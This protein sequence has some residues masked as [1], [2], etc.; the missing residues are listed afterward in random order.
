MNSNVFDRMPTSAATRAQAEE[1]QR[2][3]DEAEYQRGRGGAPDPEVPRGYADA[4]LEMADMEAA[5]DEAADLARSGICS[6][7]WR[8]SRGHTDTAGAV[9]DMHARGDFPSRPIADGE[10]PEGRDL[11]LD[12]GELVAELDF[13]DGR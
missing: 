5:A 1:R 12:C 10:I 13:G 3:F 2:I 9:A 6:H 11:C 8:L 7:W 4:D